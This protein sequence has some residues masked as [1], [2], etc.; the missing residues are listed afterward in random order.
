MFKDLAMNVCNGSKDSLSEYAVWIA[1]G[2]V[3][4]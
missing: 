3:L 1:K 2:G 4:S